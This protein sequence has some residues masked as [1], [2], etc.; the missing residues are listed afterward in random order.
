MRKISRS[1]RFRYWFDNTM[2]RGPIAL[3][4]WLFVLSA[5]LILVVAL[6]IALAG[7][8]TA[9]EGGLSFGRLLW[10]NLMRTLDA[11]NLNG[12]EEVGIPFAFGMLTMTLGG[13]FIVSTLIGV[14]TSGIEG[15]LETLR[16]GRSFVVESGHTVILGWSTQIFEIISELV[17]AN[18]NQPRSR[19]VILADK[20]KLEMEDELRA[21]VGNTGR[22]RVVCRTGSPTDLTDLE[23]VNPHEARS[24][25]ILG[26]DSDK[27]DTQVIKSILALTNNPR[28]RAAPY[29]IVAEIQDPRN[30]EVARMVGRDEAEL[31]LVG[32]LIARITV[33]TSQQSGLSVVYTEL[34]DF[35]GDE[36]YFHTEPGLVGKR[37]HD[38]LFA[39]EDSA[40]MGL[41]TA[42]GR[43]SL[44][45]PMDQV[46]EA[47]DRVVVVSAD[48][49]T[50]RMSNG[51]S[52]NIDLT[53]IRQSSAHPRAPQQT[54]VLGWNE[55]GPTI[56][57]EL[58]NYVAP[59]SEV[60]VV[61]DVIEDPTTIVEELGELGNQRVSFVRGDITNR[62]TLDS[63]DPSRFQHAIVLSHSDHFDPEEAD[64]RTLVTL[65]H[66][67]NI[68]EQSPHPMAIVSEML[69]V[70]NR[71]LAEVTK[72]DDFIVSDKLVGLLLT[73][74]SENKHLAAVFQDLFDDDGSEIYL[75]PAGD[76]VEPG[77]PINFHTVV[78]AAAR[79][80]EVA[81]G[82]RLRAAANAADKSY[83]VKLNPVKSQQVT[84]GDADRII[85]LARS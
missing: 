73:Q 76:Y 35:G 55:R 36:I 13:I 38:A 32:D 20:D 41:Q 57:R 27:P 3:I 30:M 40:I 22:T 52:P 7:F 26:S 4:G 43:V 6:V 23:I 11:G 83:G 54:L 10:T 59:G 2:S 72:A 46:I 84:F 33:Q 82:Y 58:N 68:E 29:H 77:R 63:L 67:R 37:F 64:S 74:I 9:Q 24:I 5:A 12:D 71:E 21:K 16:K 50:I 66:L 65:L 19:I 78:E 18:A 31:I 15:K 56:V 47:G 53:A 48:D 1:D 28:R 75:K 60:V 42:D 81:L 25:I 34:L 49:D 61:S 8:N 39:F 80:G 70:R 44:N 79:R 45:P 17:L 62:R 85:V 69:D 51:A 14:L